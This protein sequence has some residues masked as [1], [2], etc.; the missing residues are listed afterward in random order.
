MTFKA[1]EYLQKRGYNFNPMALVPNT[2]ISDLV[3]FQCSLQPKVWLDLDGTRSIGQILDDIRRGTYQRE[4][5]SLRRELLRGNQE[6][7]I[8]GKR[9]LPG[10]T[11]CGTFRGHRRRQ[12]LDRYNFLVVI[13]IDKLTE[14]ELMKTLL[15]LS[16]DDYVLSYWRSPSNRGIK[17]LVHLKFSRDLHTA[18]I[19]KAHRIAFTQLSAY[20]KLKHCIEIDES[21]SDT[22]RLCFYSYDQGLVLK[23]SGDSFE[24]D[25]SP[26]SLEGVTTP[27][28]EFDVVPTIDER[29]RFFN[30]E[31]RN[32]PKHRKMV[33]SIIR[34]L[35]KRGTSITRSY[36][37]WYRVA[38]AVANTF[39]HDVGERYFLRLCRLDGT[40]HDEVGSKKLLRYC[41][42]NSRGKI[43]FRTIIRFA[44]LNGYKK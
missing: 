34:T 20:F 8:M 6:Q 7:Y 10:V 13:D 35:T 18:E 11:F 37:E 16:K 27:I 23:A 38:F 44:I 40:N 43:T 29:N 32:N 30:P 1:H 3:R 9:A 24:V 26:Q 5:A 42:L 14:D 41:Y 21:G 25:L 33:A 17:G 36:E 19:D 22:T 15:V 39:T 4:V 12:F 28:A 2:S 31:G